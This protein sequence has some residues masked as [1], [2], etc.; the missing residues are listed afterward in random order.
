MIAV[1]LICGSK[2]VESSQADGRFSVQLA[3]ETCDVEFSSDHIDFGVISSDHITSVYEQA[4]GTLGTFQGSVLHPSKV[5]QAAP[6]R[7]T[8]TCFGPDYSIYAD[9]R[10]TLP[11]GVGTL[12]DNKIFNDFT[13]IGFLMRDDTD[14][15]VGI[16]TLRSNDP[17]RWTS[18][19]N[20]Y[21]SYM[22]NRTK[23]IPNESSHGRSGDYLRLGGTRDAVFTRFI[24]LTPSLYVNPDQIDASKEIQLTGSIEFRI[25]Y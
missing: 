14:T 25:Y 5:A 15:A 1:M 2:V 8:Y 16:V 17:I 19:N 18:G 9:F 12:Q 22:P 21:L 20:S 23:I 3:V 24:E 13:N 10:D 4:T 7:L 11:A 6:I